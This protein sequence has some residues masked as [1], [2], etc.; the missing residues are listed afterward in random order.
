LEAQPTRDETVHE[1]QDRETDN[2]YSV[3]EDNVSEDVEGDQIETSFSASQANIPAHISVEPA[4]TPPIDDQTSNVDSVSAATSPASN[5]EDRVSAKDHGAPS[6]PETTPP[7]SSLTP[8][9]AVAPVGNE[10]N[11]A[12]YIQSSSSLHEGDEE[13]SNG[14]RNLD[15][16]NSSMEDEDLGTF[17][18]IENRNKV[19]DF[20]SPSAIDNEES[21]NEFSTFDTMEV[22]EEDGQFKPLDTSSDHENT[23]EFG[24]LD[25]ED[26][27]QNKVDEFESFEATVDQEHDHSDISDGGEADEFGGFDNDD[28]GFGDD[29]EF[30]G[31]DDNDGFDDADDFGAFDDNNDDDGFDDF[32]RANIKNAPAVPPSDNAL[33]S[34]Q[35][36]ATSFQE[37]PAN[38]KNA[39]VSA[40]YKCDN[41]VY[42]TLTL[43]D[44]N[45][46]RL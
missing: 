9:E 29:D 16:I 13:F 18:Q 14:A 10:S 36:V 43:I 19:D 17:G 44:I 2:P 4:V 6:K 15:D 28:D 21:F 5:M 7:I 30:G 45:C 37:I 39:I 3:V 31:F 11:I 26:A 27:E 33:H 22:K 35:P 8:D 46:I 41:S 32:D 40:N 34:S 12:D 1:K 25:V 23:D 20:E 24:S 38:I 42:S